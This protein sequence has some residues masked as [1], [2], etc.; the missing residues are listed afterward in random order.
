MQASGLVG[1]ENEQSL[2]R[3]NHAVRFHHHNPS[4]APARRHLLQRVR[5]LL[6]AERRVVLT[7]DFG[8]RVQMSVEQLTDLVAQ[9]KSGSLDGVC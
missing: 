5:R 4:G 7:D 9:A 3:S 2:S 8:Q 1:Q 6:P